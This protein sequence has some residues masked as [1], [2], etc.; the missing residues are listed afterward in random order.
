M[1]CLT[2]GTQPREPTKHQY[3]FDSATVIGFLKTY[4]LDK[5]YKLNIENNHA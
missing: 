1:V 4:G 2:I 5:D 3:D